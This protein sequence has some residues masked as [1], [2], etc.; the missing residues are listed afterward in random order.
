MTRFRRITR[1][2]VLALVVAFALLVVL[3]YRK[4]GARTE[5]AHDPV[6]DTLLKESGGKRDTMRFRDFQYDETRASEGRYRLRATEAIKFEEKGEKLFRLKDVV[7]ESRE[8]AG[9][10][11]ISVRAPRAEMIEGSRAFRIFDGVRI[12]GEETSLSA[13]SFR[14]DPARRLL[15]SEGPV[16]ALRGALVAHAASG[17]LGVRDGNLVLDG[18]AHL[19]GRAESGHAVDLAA[20]HVVVS[21]D[22]RL[23]ATGGAVLK[24]DRFILR[25]ESVSRLAEPDGSR[26]RA[27][28]DAFLLVLPD[29]DQPPAALTAQ[30]AALEMRV[31]ASGQPTGLEADGGAPGL[32]RLD[33]GPASTSGTAGARRARAPHF[34]GRFENGRFRELTVPNRLDAAE[35]GRAGGPVGSGLRTLTAGFARVLFL[36]DGRSIETATFENGVELTDGKRATLKAPHGTLRGRDDTAVFSG[37]SDV[38]ARYHDERGA[39]TARSLSWNA[40][41]ERLDAAGTVKAS[42]SPGAGPGRGGFLGGDGK[43]PFFSESDTLKLLSRT[44]TLVLTGSVRAWQNENVLRCGTLELDDVAKTMRAEQ[45]V[46][47]FFRR[48]T[49]PVKGTRPLPGG[50]PSET[51]NAAGDVLIHREEERFVRLEGHATMT[52]GIFTMS[53]DVTDIRLAPDRTIEYTEARGAVVVE[54]RAQHRR[55]EGTKAIWRPQ[56]EAVTLEGAPATALDGKG[57]R[58]TGAVLTFRQKSSQVD[59]ETGGSVPTETI[60]KPEGS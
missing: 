29:G 3:S 7:F 9:E 54:D 39:I 37:E 11:V 21:R 33:L 31:D 13:A 10:R 4:P 49:T 41:E 35:S 26:L 53:S 24:T 2:A 42:Y 38:P 27:T 19:S 45:K 55:G 48:E 51:V 16:A 34:S 46:Q 8:G 15:A 57:N 14:Y 59:V 36:P 6:A 60:L 58:S 17:K 56:T 5:G 28:T 20:P 1:A 47:A 25:S 50:R 30:G 32:A 23:D 22:G 44:S 52:S 18:D 12:E 40:R 43:S